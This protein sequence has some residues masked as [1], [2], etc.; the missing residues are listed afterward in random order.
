MKSVSIKNGSIEGKA[1][2]TWKTREKSAATEKC[3]TARKSQERGTARK[4]ALSI[5][6]EESVSNHFWGGLRRRCSLSW[7]GPRSLRWGWDP[8]REGWDKEMGWDNESQQ[9]Q[10]KA[11]MQCK[12]EIY[13]WSA[14]DRTDQAEK[15]IKEAGVGWVWAQ[16]SCRTTGVT[17]FG[18]GIFE[19]VFN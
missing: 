6:Q 19:E 12:D 18:N 11:R 13:I 15:Q 4:T 5:K 1:T 16:N 7:T 8:R 9:K 10:K 17:L 3:H 14:K 2:P